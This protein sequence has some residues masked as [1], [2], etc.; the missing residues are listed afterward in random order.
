MFLP[1]LQVLDPPLILLAIHSY[2]VIICS[3]V[4]LF[5][6]YIWINLGVLNIVVACAC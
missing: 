4:V 2:M 5:Y 1:T 6:K 3:Y